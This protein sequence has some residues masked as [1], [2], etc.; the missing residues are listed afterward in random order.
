MIKDF[1]SDEERMKQARVLCEVIEQAN[2]A[3]DY[4]KGEQES[5]ALVPSSCLLLRGTIPC[6]ELPAYRLQ[7]QD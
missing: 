6:K 7:R 4:L 2:I 1:G 3:R 5:K